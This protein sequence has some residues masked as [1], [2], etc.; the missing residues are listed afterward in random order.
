ADYCDF[1]MGLDDSCG[2]KTAFQLIPEG[3]Y[4]SF[5]EIVSRIRSRGFEVNI[6]DLDHDGR[7]YKQKD[8]FLERAKRINNYARRYGMRG[9]RSGS[10]HRRQEWFGN[11]DF[12]YDMSVP[13]VSHLEPQKGGC[14]TV[15]PYFVD[16]VLE[17]PLT[18]IQDHGMFYVLSNRSL[19]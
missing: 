7:L 4:K 19:D 6:H 11:L 16:G 13:T 9:F 2:I 12:Q 14:C 18:T 3:A 8:V 5:E 1:L 15:T 17:L 10:M